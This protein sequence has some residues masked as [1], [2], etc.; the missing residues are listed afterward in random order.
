[1]SGQNER[2]TV[3][4]ELTEFSRGHL[5][6]ALA[7]FAAEGWRSPATPSPLREALARAGG[8]RIDLLSRAGDYYLALG[9]EPIP[10]FGLRQETIASAR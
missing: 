9:A 7:L 10:G 8:I 4:L 2:P 3:G 6:G 5:V 1:M